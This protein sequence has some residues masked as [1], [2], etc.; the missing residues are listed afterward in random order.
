MFEHQLNREL[1]QSRQIAREDQPG[2]HSQQ[3]HGHEQNCDQNVH[4][5]ITTKENPLCTMPTYSF[6][7]ALL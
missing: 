2:S 5:S 6:V 7:R 3:N 1:Y 4:C